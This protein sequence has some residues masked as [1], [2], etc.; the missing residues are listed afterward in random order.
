M[1]ENGQVFS[2]GLYGCRASATELRK[3]SQEDREKLRE[4]LGEADEP[5]QGNGQ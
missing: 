1:S 3:L 5:C 2:P 4:I